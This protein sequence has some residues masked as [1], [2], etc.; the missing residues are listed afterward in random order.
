MALS[1][2]P[3]QDLHLDIP[4]GTAGSKST[5]ATVIT[6][7]GYLNGLQLDSTVTYLYRLLGLWRIESYNSLVRP[8]SGKSLEM[9]WYHLI[10][11]RIQA[12]SFRMVR[13]EQWKPSSF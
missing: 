10:F 9:N 8:P 4:Q 12:C 3:L 5:T 6:A 7:G 13:L 11:P 2:P 1:F